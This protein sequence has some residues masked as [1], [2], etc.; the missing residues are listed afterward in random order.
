MKWIASLFAALAA[1]LAVV[2]P[3]TSARAQFL[4]AFVAS[5]GSDANNNNCAQRTAPCA[6]IQRV[7]NE[8]SAEGRIFC[9]DSGPYTGGTIT[10]SV[11]IDCP[12]A[13][14]L[15]IGNTFDVN[16]AG[17]VVVLR[18]ITI[19]GSGGSAGFIGV[20]VIQANL[21]QIEHCKISGFRVN[22]AQGIRYA[23]SSGGSLFITDTVIFQNGLGIFVDAGSGSAL[24]TLQRVQIV[25]NG[26]G[27]RATG[28]G[29]GVVYAT[30]ADSI[31]SMNGTNGFFATSG[32]GASV[33]FEIQRS[34]ANLNGGIGIL[35]DGASNI[36][37]GSTTV[38]ANGV[39]FGRTN[40]GT[41]T[42]Y[43]DNR[44]DTNSNNGSATG[45]IGTM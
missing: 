4:A 45:M 11:T 41:I 39:G 19:D 22:A 15:G 8:T 31:S 42:S 43:G 12:D 35:A 36:V 26:E 34:V 28:G 1:M 7:L 38:T 37:I 10:K 32:G 13:V 20:N 27:F 5:T 44:V 21:V 30:I 23:S 9:L 18:N 25:H 3:V 24:V 33:F 17:I 40:G 6:S 14:V 16:G 29:G 2:L